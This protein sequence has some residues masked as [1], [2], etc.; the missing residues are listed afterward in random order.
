MRAAI[1]SELLLRLMNATT[2]Q[3]AAV[4]RILGCKAEIGNQ[5]VEIETTDDGP[6][7]TEDVALVLSGIRR[8]VAAIRKDV[9]DL[10][11]GNPP[12]EPVSDNEALRLFALVDA[13]ESETNY[14]KAPVIRVFL[15]YCGQGIKRDEVARRCRCAP[16][17]VTL[18]LQA[19]EKKLGR[20]ASELRQLSGH[21]DRI[22]ESLTDERARRVHRASALD[23][24]GEEWD[25]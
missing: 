5:R 13:L 3:Y 1:P 8:E 24:P 12:A 21:F 16:S 4:E 22:A 19:I 2:E 9:G 25:E 20:K 23:Q 17:L 14:R 10:R 11:K 6:Q 18:R 7:T 15:L